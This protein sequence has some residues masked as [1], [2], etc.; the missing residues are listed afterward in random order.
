M[1]IQPDNQQFPNHLIGESSPYLLQHAFNPVQWYPWNDKAWEKAKKEDKLVLVSVGYSSCHWCHVMEH[2]SFEDP[3]TAKLMNE[4]FICIKVDREERPDIDQV[5]MTAVQLMSGGGGWPLNCFCLP[6]GRPIYGGTYFPNATWNDLLLKLNQ[7]YRQNKEQ[8]NQYADELTMGIAQTETITLNKAEANFKI[9]DLKKIV[10]E[11]KKHFDN[12]EGGPNRAPKFPLPNN[13]EFLLHYYYKTKDENILEYVK[14]TLTKMAYGG[15]YDQVGGGFARYSTDTF[16]KVPHFEKMLYDN[17]QLVSLY[18]HAYQLTKDELYKNVVYETLK[19]ISREMTSEEGTFFSA[20]D[21]DSEGEE[22]KYYTWKKDELEKLIGSDF[23]IFSEYFNVNEKGI[24]EH[25]NYILLR[26]GNEKII[27]DKSNLTIEQLNNLIS[28]SKNILLNERQKRIA[29]GLDDKQLTSWNA[30]MIKGYCDAYNVFNNEKFLESAKRC[31]NSILAEV[32][33]S[34]GCLNHSFKNGK[35]TI[36][37]FLEDYSF[38]IEALLALYQSTFDEQWLNEARRFGDYVIQHFYDEKTGMF[39]FTSC[40]DVS[41]IARKKEIHDNV[42]PA[43]NSSMAKAFFVLGIYFD[44]KKYAGI[45]LQML[46]NVK[47]EMQHYASSYS[48]WGMLFLNFALPF[49]EIVIAGKDAHQKRKEINQ[50]YLPGK[51]LAG[52]EDGKSHLVLLEQ[53]YVD[54]KTLIYVCRNKTCMLPVETVEGAIKQLN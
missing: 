35:A 17:A 11:W 34:D 46:K 23:T 14:L 36:N 24:W 37:G 54:D 12:S 9:E 18:S 22:G 42:I 45:A 15:I 49:N 25:G 40:S 47:D 5:Y 29:P 43:S 48:N 3:A 10:E 2:E 41:L 44:E 30:L 51:I 50:Y 52:S 32:K 13:Y 6:D 53:R 21:A 16:W 39:F 28:N 7:F 26:T 38:F 31:A 20:L 8:A 33:K 27:A 1:E 19:F 4:H